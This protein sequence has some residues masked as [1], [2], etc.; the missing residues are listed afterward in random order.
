MNAGNITGIILGIKM[1]NGKFKPKY[2][3]SAIISMTLFIL[4]LIGSIIAFIYG[5]ANTNIEFIIFPSLLIFSI[6]YVLLISPYTQKASNYHIEF[7]SDNSLAGFRLLY[8]NKLVNILYRIDQNGKIAFVNNISKLSCISY[9]DG[10][11]M[12]NIVKY[13]IINYFSKWLHDNNLLSNEVTVTFE[14]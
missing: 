7:Q 1:V 11:K 9:A 14:Q 2:G 5:I 12:N 10:S 6:S 13:K 3:A 4:V 8:R